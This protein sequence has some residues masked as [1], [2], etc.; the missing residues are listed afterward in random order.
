MFGFSKIVK[1]ILT[2]KNIPISEFAVGMGFSDKYVYDL[3]SKR[4]RS[5]WNEDSIQRACDI[6]GI[7]IRFI[8]KSQ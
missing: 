1:K 8:S 2:E 6:L 5:R 7:E 4:N 3:L